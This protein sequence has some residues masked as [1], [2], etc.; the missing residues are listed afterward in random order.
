MNLQI[1]GCAGGIGGLDPHTTCLLVDQDILLDAGTGLAKLELMQLLQIDH[2]FLSHTHLDHIAGLVLLLDAVVGKRRTPV[3]VYGSEKVITSLREHIF[4]W[5]IWPDFNQIPSLDAPILRYQ[6]LAETQQ[7]E[8]N[9]R[10]ISCHGVRHIE[11]SYAYLVSQAQRGFAFTG[12]LASSPEFWQYL[13]T[14]PSIKTVIVDCSFVN[15]EQDLA[16]RS[17]HFCPQ[18]LLN[19]IAGLPD[20]MEFLIYHLKPGQ[21]QQVMTELQQGK[22]AQRLSAL[23]S[24]MRFVF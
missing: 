6:V 17:M 5:A 8:L 11:G 14:Q 22:P 1:L 10:Q 15:S 20:D 9:G 3:T 19:D 24:G 12:D 13:L 21:E 23:H 16:R 2:V 4:N 7:V 18:D